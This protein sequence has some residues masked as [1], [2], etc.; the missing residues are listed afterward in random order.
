[1]KKN[2]YLSL[3]HVCDFIDWM[4]PR[5]SGEVEFRHSYINNKGKKH[6]RCNSVYDAFENYSWPFTCTLPVD[7][8]VKGSSFEESERILQTIESGMRSA[9]SNNESNSLLSYSSAMLEWGGVTRSNRQKL[10]RMGDGIVEYYRSA[11]ALLDP[12]TVD[13][14]GEFEGI[15][16]NSGFTKLYSM[17]I[18]DYII[19][20]SRV[21][22]SLGLL[23]R[24]F[25]EEKKY[26]YIPEGLN[27]SYG[28]S[29]PTKSD[30]GMIN[31]RNPSSRTYKFTQ[32]ANNRKKHIKNNIYANWLLSELSNSSKFTEQKNPIRALESA[33]FMIGY[34]VN[35]IG[36]LPG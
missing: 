33:L 35:S 36:E 16:M 25:L 12:N 22:A 4:V 21:G 7:G 18:D 5:I 10:E 6:W 28:N 17:V 11:R 3:E 8:Y 26:G 1:M 13:S 24:Y 29:R 31:K 20:D 23:V 2:E 30:M 14:D 19:Y 15:Y 9:I 34:E 32:L 27:Y